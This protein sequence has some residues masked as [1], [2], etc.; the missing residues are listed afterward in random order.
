MSQVAGLVVARYVLGVEPLAS[1]P[2]DEV[3]Q[4]TSPALRAALAGPRPRPG[5]NDR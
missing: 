5:H 4:R 3:V 2:V 1:M